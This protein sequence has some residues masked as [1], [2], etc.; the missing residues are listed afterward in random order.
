MSD[1]IMAT[2][3]GCLMYKGE[4]IDLSYTL[5]PEPNDFESDLI[6]RVALAISIG[7]DISACVQVCLDAGQSAGR[8][9][10]TYDAAVILQADRLKQE[11]GEDHATNHTGQ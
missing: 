4:C 5:L 7:A 8:A 9:Q 3:A 11:E 6:R 1:C 2:Q 10:L